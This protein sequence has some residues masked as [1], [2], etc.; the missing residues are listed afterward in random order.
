MTK[1]NTTQKLTNEQLKAHMATIY[2]ELK[3]VS[4][5]MQ[6]IP[7]KKKKAVLT[8]SQKVLDDLEDL[9]KLAF[10][11]KPSDDDAQLY[12]ILDKNS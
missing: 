7:F 6:N 10:D 4:G 5:V 12:T 11:Y 2:Q 8:A 3:T 9:L 1:N